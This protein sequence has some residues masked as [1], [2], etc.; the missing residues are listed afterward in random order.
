MYPCTRDCINGLRLHRVQ[1]DID[2]QLLY[3]PSRLYNNHIEVALAL[4]MKAIYI[5]IYMCVCLHR[6][7]EIGV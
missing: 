6:E 5:E 3:F 1:D 2:K 4:M 7:Q